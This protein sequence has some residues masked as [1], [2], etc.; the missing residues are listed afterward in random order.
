M[1]LS[2]SY[3]LFPTEDYLHAKFHC[4]RSSGLDFYTVQTHTC[5]HTHTHTHTQTQ[6][7]IDFYVLD[8]S[9]FPSLCFRASLFSII[10]SVLC[11]SP[12]PPLPTLS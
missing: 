9:I 2:P 1:G 10:L 8:L 4:D 11:F 3:E 5:T 12:P 7:H 6:T